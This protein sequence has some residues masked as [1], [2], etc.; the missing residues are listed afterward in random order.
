MTSATAQ[1]YEP[2]DSLRAVRLGMRL[3]QDEMAQAIRRSGVE[4]GEPNDASKRLVQRWEAGISRT[5]RPVYARALERLTGRPVEALGFAL[6]VPMA[7]VRDDGR[8]GHDLEPGP[9]G[10]TPAAAG[11]R[12]VPAAVA[13]DYSGVWLSKY[14]YYSS[15]RSSSFA[16]QHFVVLVQHGPRLTARSLPNGSSNPGSPLSL[17]LTADSNIV[18]GTWME[19]TATDGYYAGAR[20]HGALQLLVEPTGRRMSGKWIGFGKDFDVNSGPWELVFQDAS[21]SRGTIE[22]YSRP[23]E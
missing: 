15:G 4:L 6:A 8:G 12:T 11:Q 19:Q 7:R 3:S 13:E 5:P 21:T 1:A 18:T 22:R 17:D 20:Y 9:E 10:V 2:N 23:P 16:G 14:E